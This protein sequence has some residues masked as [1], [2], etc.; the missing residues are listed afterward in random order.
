MLFNENIILENDSVLLRPLE[1]N[2][3]R[4]L[5]GFAINEPGIWK[6]SLV[7]ISNAEDLNKYILQALENR[8][9]EKE[10][11]FVVIDKKKNKYAGCT[12]FYDIQF[13][14]KYLQLGYTWYGEDFQGT[15][16][17]KNCKLLLLEFAFEKLGMERVEFRAH[18][19]NERSKRA[20][21]NIGC[22]IEGVLRSHLPAIEGGR[23][24]S[25]VLSILKDEWLG[26]VK[27]NLM[28]KIN[29]LNKSI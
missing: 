4:H 19:E 23:R 28:N 15:Y 29:L 18:N 26:G 22:I 25:V 9:Q 11:P 6:Y 8:K 21:Q 17:N 10:Y 7:K 2:D 14:Y 13:E 16:I 20:M 27:E 1:K 5:E 24:D 12:R 3:I